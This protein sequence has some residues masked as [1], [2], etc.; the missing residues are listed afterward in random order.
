M[1]CYTFT[2]VQCVIIKLNT[3]MCYVTYIVCTV[4]VSER[5]KAFL[6]KCKILNCIFLIKFGS[7][8]LTL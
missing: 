5:V 8:K 2:Y 3:Y 1:S 4:N 7:E 6:I